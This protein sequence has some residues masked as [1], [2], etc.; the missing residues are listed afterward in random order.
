MFFTELFVPLLIAA[1][2]VS[3][4]IKK[5]DILSA[6]VEGAKENLIVCAELCPTLILLMTAICMFNDSGA[7]N[8]ISELLKPLTSLLGLPA[9]C[10]PLMLI[11]PISGSGSLAVLEKLLGANPIDSA[12]ARTACVMMGATETTLYTIVVYYGAVRKKADAGV[13]VSSFTAD[14]TGFLF[15]SLTVKLFFS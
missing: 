8:G 14:I 10:T 1:V 13:F 7:A 11:R 15:A 3:A 4:V 6:F 9:E 2:L 12:A 5:V